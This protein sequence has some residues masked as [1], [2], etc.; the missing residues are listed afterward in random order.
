MHIMYILK[1]TYR[2]KMYSSFVFN[3]VKI[4]IDR[5]KNVKIEKESGKPGCSQGLMS[6]RETQGRTTVMEI[7]L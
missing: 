6:I 1:M 5:W 3:Y 2:N 4:E 7:K